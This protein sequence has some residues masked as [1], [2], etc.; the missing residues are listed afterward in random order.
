MPNHYVGDLASPDG[1][2]TVHPD[3]SLHSQL[4]QDSLGSTRSQQV[5]ISNDLLSF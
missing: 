4:K 5:A 2:S 3:N 1:C